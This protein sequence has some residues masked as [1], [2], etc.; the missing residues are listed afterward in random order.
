MKRYLY[1][2]QSVWAADVEMEV[3][4]KTNLLGVVPVSVDFECVRH[5]VFSPVGPEIDELDVRCRLAQDTGGLREST[6][7]VC[8]VLMLQYHIG[9]WDWLGCSLLV[10]LACPFRVVTELEVLSLYRKARFSDQN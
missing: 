2:S 7:P 3:R 10:D 5:A 8:L 4:M 9:S 1:S 6:F